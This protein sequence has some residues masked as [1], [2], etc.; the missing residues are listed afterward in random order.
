MVIKKEL[1]LCWGSTA[2]E[3][4]Q[5]QT[6][7]AATHGPAWSRTVWSHLHCVAN[8]SLHQQRIRIWDIFSII[9]SP[10]I[11]N[12]SGYLPKAWHC[13]KEAQGCDCSMDAGSDISLGSSSPCSSWKINCSLVQCLLSELQ[14]INIC[15]LPA[16]ETVLCAL[17]VILAAPSKHMQNPLSWTAEHTFMNDM[18]MLR[19]WMHEIG[20]S[21]KLPLDRLSWWSW[22]GTWRP[23]RVGD[24]QA[25]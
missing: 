11:S 22:Y 7:Y 21:V 5:I 6:R 19:W 14:A 15:H 23:R 12:N 3:L 2:P 13:Q 20:R 4:F 9:W 1:Q 25:G 17:C 18:C 10:L 24:H 8:M 16:M